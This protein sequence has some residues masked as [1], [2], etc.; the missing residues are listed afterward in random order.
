MSKYLVTGTSVTKVLLAIRKLLASI[1]FEAD[2]CWSKKLTGILTIGVVIAL[3]SAVLG[4]LVFDLSFLSALLLYSVTGTGA[5][6]F[7]AWRRF[8]CMTQHE[9]I[10]KDS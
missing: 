8:I 7:V 4:T 3:M 1:K 9:E 2:H 5:T 6:L 10:L